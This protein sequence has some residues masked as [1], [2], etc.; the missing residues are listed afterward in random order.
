MT[1][2]VPGRVN[3]IGEHIDYHNLPVL[4]MAIQRR[5]SITFDE[6]SDPMIQASSRGYDMREFALSEGEPFAAGDWGNYL[7]AAAQLVTRRWHLSRGLN[8]AIE[9]DLPVA[10]GLSSSS[11]LMT[12]IALALLRVNGITPTLD[13]LMELLPD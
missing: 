9:S 8:A 10:A 4:P 13:D 6:R 7:K 2:S 1:I 11:A 3:L 5:V 12:G